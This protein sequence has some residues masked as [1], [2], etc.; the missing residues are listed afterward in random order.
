MK[1][2]RWLFVLFLVI[3][4]GVGSSA[5]GAGWSDSLMGKDL[6]SLLGKQLGLTGDQSKGGIGAIFGLA[7]EKM[8]SADFDKMTSTVPGV[9]K[10][11]SKAKKLGLLDKP[12]G[13]KDGLSAAFTKLGISKENADKMIP[14][15][16][17]LVGIIGGE[18][19]KTMLQSVLG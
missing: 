15:V 14:A 19:A 8:T 3:A 9:D 17:D 16:T 10:Y 5:W 12:I 6:D 18:Q 1:P 7:K 2:N 4:A 11:V 13:N